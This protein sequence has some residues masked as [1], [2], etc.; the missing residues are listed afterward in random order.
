MLEVVRSGTRKSRGG[1]VEFDEEGR[2]DSVS[3]SLSGGGAGDSDFA[4]HV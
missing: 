3:V 1:Q 4:A 2:P